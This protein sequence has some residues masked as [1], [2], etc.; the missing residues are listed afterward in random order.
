M[1]AVPLPPTLPGGPEGAALHLPV[2]TLR[3]FRAGLLAAGEAER[4]RGHLAA[5]EDCRDL[6]DDV[7]AFFDPDGPGEEETRVDAGASWERLEGSLAREGW[8]AARRPRRRWRAAAAL[9]IAAAL[10]GL[11]VLG[12]ARLVF[13]YGLE[14]T[15]LVAAGAYKRGP[16]EVVSVR[17]PVFLRL[18]PSAPAGAYRVEL[19]DAGGSPVRSY[20]EL[21]VDRGGR[22]PL[23]LR[24]W[25]LKPGRYRLVVRGASQLPSEPADEFDFGIQGLRN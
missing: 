13:G 25:E 22:L 17:L 6:A 9:P 20:G 10:V 2:E 11:L 15:V 14:P 21:R 24:R 8:F 7:G 18:I 4:V 16:D 19:R 5:C 1:A 23:R 3:A 12:V